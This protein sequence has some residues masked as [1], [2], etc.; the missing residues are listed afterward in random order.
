MSGTNKIILDTS[1]LVE[2]FDGTEKGKEVE[3]Q[4]ENCDEALLPTLVLAEFT[5]ILKRRGF[6]PIKFLSN[7]TVSTFILPLLSPIAIAAG[8][9]HAEIRK[10][11]KDISLAD[12][13]VMVHAERENAKVITTDPHFK[14]CKNAVIL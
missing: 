13:I 14:H 2:L 7:L 9:L 11:E 8:G 4:I 6:E 1:A 3:K 5:S 12:C 10:K